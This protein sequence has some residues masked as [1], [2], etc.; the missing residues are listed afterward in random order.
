MKCRTVQC[1]CLCD[2]K[3]LAAN[4]VLHHLWVGTVNVRISI[5]PFPKRLFNN[6][7]GMYWRCHVS[8]S[9]NADVNKHEIPL[10]FIGIF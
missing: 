8:P 6:A 2:N 10:N 9:V 5:T 1:S 3:C 7:S 4:N